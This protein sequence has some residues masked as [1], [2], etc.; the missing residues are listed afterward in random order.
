MFSCGRV[1]NQNNQTC[2]HFKFF[3]LEITFLSPVFF[4]TLQCSYNVEN[5]EFAIKKMAQTTMRSEI[6]KITLDTVFRERETLNVN[7]VGKIPYNCSS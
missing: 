3:F 5:A 7:I 4:S 2:N 1:V 6:G